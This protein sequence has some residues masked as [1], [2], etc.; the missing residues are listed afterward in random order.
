MQWSS[1]VRQSEVDK[2]PRSLEESVNQIWMFLS[3]VTTPKGFAGMEW[4]AEFKK[5]SLM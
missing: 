3:P 1:F 5:W 4:K 2:A